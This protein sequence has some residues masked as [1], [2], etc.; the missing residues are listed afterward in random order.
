MA[1]N[2]YPLMQSTATGAIRRQ[3]V[4][5]CDAFSETVGSNSKKHLK[6]FLLQVA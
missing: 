6:E 4:D 1:D 2:I 3:T 5:C